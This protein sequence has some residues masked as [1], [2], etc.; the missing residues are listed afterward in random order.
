MMMLSDELTDLELNEVVISIYLK[1]ESAVLKYIST[2]EEEY[3]VEFHKGFVE[4]YKSDYS[5]IFPSKEI[6]RIIRHI[7]P[8][9]SK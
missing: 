2:D 5:I 7:Q 9:T 6:T 1:G 8:K 3:S 4:I